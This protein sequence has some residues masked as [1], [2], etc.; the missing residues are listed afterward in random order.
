MCEVDEDNEDVR[1][2]V[3]DEKMRGRGDGRTMM[4]LMYEV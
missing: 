3:E 2:M 1:T 4:L